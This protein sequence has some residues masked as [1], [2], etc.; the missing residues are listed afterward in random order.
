LAD[1]FTIKSLRGEILQSTLK[2]CK[3]M[4]VRTRWEFNSM[5]K[6]NDFE[7]MITVLFKKMMLYGKMFR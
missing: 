3:F 5:A 1:L 6:V 4:R 7:A 2:L